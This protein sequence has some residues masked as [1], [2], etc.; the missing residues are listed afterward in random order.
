M[1]RTQYLEVVEI[2]RFALVKDCYAAGE[3]LAVLNY[4]RWLLLLFHISSEWDIPS[5]Y[6]LLLN[7][8][9]GSGLIPHLHFYTRYMIAP[10]L[11]D[12]FATVRRFI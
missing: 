11:V 8:R 6:K 4:E 10:N 3:S 2:E 5:I 9:I 12:P 1:I 7:I